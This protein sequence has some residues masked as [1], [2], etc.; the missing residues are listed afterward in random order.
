MDRKVH[1]KIYRANHRSD[2]VFHNIPWRLKNS[3]FYVGVKNFL[4]KEAVAQ[5]WERDN[6]DELNQPSLDRIDSS[7]HYTFDNCRFIEMKENSKRAVKDKWD[8][9]SNLDYCNNGHQF[10]ESNTYWYGPTKTYRSC[11][12]CKRVKAKKEW[13]R[14][15]K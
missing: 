11:R 10:I 8:K 15:K 14:R 7:G 4:T 12:I 2:H 1:D 3:K 5:L 13:A 6:A 9:R